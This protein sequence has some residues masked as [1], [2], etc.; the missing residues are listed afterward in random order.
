MNKTRDF[1]NF[2]FRNPI[3]TEKIR[4]KRNRKEINR[5]MFSSDG[6]QLSRLGKE[7]LATQLIKII[8]NDFRKQNK[9]NKDDKGDGNIL[10][11]NDE[12]L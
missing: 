1:E 8:N 6:L 11:P 5:E 3:E 9:R 10:V 7:A 12:A 4:T 2:T